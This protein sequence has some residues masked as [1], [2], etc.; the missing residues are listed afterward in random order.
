M[1]QMPQDLN[2]R[3]A[4]ILHADIGG[5]ILDNAARGWLG[6]T[7]AKLAEEARVGLSTVKDFEAG[8]RAPIANNLHAMKRALEAWGMKLTMDG[9]AKPMEAF[10]EEPDDSNQAT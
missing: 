1:A 10:T 6:W 8:K 2:S 5:R 3:H 7:Q 4:H 9:V